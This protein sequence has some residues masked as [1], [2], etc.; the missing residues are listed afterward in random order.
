MFQCPVLQF[1]L[2]SHEPPSF[3]ISSQTLKPPR[4]YI[5]ISLLS[6]CFPI[7]VGEANFFFLS[8][9]GS[10]DCFALRLLLKSP[11]F[12]FWPLNI[13]NFPWNSSSNEFGTL[14]SIQTFAFLLHSYSVT[15]NKEN[16]RWFHLKSEINLNN[17]N[18]LLQNM[19]YC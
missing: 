2:S 8:F 9:E 5:T 12:V 14:R 18:V 10:R 4:F 13:Q 17:S 1:P 7:L 6:P 11:R 3:V 15:L 16:F 19:C